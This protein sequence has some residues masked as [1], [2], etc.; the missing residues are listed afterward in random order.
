MH[1][2][3]ASLSQ[4]TNYIASWHCSGKKVA[5]N[6]QNYQENN[7]PALRYITPLFWKTKLLF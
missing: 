6:K 7:N 4:L 2:E 5:A 3:L 1:G